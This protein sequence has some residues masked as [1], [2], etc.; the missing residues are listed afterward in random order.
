M[1]KVRVLQLSRTFDLNVK[2]DE[3]RQNSVLALCEA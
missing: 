3:T 1:F 2:F